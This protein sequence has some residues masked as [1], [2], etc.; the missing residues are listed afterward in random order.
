MKKNAEGRPRFLTFFLSKNF[1]FKKNFFKKKFFFSKKNFFK[2]IFFIKK[3]F[4][5]VLT[6]ISYFFPPEKKGVY[7]SVNKE[8]YFFVFK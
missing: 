2:N 7:F 1:F 6:K 4:F 8:K 5:T 3:I